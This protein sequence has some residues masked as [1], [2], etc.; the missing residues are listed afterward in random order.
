MKLGEACHAPPPLMVNSCVP[1]PP[2]APEMVI[3][4]SEAPKQV[5]FVPAAEPLRTGGWVRVILAVAVHP[6]VSRTLTA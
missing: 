4:P 1:A 6:F 3:V 5:I 2:A